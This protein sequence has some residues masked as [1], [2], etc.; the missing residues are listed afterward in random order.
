MTRLRALPLAVCLALAGC[1]GGAPSASNGTAPMQN[2]LLDPATEMARRWGTVFTDR[3]TIAAAA[4]DLGY[5]IGAM[6]AT[7]TKPAFRATSEAQIVT[8]ERSPLKT[9]TVMTMAG[10][11]AERVDGYAFS[12]DVGGDDGRETKPATESDKVPRRVLLGFLQRFGVAPDD[13]IKLALKTNRP[14]VK[15]LAGATI[16]Y[17]PSPP[18][19][20]KRKRNHRSVLTITRPGV[21]A[22]TLDTAAPRK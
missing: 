4:K 19:D 14:I 11:S 22:P 5:K 2:D 17:T 9:T 12:F 7:G 21:P 20:P 18:A 8:I 16:A 13:E 3:P 6:T 10:A 1:G 15:A